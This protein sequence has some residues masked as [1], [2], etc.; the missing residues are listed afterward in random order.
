MQAVDTRGFAFWSERVLAAVAHGVA[1]AAVPDLARLAQVL[2]RSPWWDG[3][4]EAAAAL[5][6]DA[7]GYRRMALRQAETAGDYAVLLIAWPA[8][9]ATPIHDHDGLW[10]IELVLDGVLQVESFAMEVAPAL[11]LVPRDVVPLGIGDHTTFSDRDYAHRCRNLSAQ[12]PALSLHVYG[13]ALQRYGAYD[14][15]GDGHWRRTTQQA[16]LEPAGN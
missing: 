15:D 10:G 7:P 12:R 4:P 5:R 3:C 13:G 1:D 2:A 11:R 14:Q 9:H 6:A 16:E 8:G